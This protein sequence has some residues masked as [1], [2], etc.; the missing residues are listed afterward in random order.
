MSFFNKL[1]KLFKKSEDDKRNE[2]K[3]N[4]IESKDETNENDRGCTEI[5]QESKLI[6]DHNRDE[7]YFANI[8]NETALPGYIIERNV[9]PVVFDEAAHPKCKPITFLIKKDDKPVLAVMIMKSN[10]MTAMISRGTYWIL[11]DK[12]IKYIRF[13]KE[14]LNEETYV[15]DRVKKHLDGAIN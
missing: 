1:F 15:L 3:E 4:I 9:H 10:Q 11:E 13:F 14:M 12:G 2:T 6:R 5:S 8:I 7:E